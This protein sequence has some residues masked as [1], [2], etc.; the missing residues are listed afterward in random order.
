LEEANYY[1]EA[2]GVTK[3]SIKTWKNQDHHKNY[4]APGWQKIIFVTKRVAEKLSSSFLITSKTKNQKP[5]TNPRMMP[6]IEL[7]PQ[8]KT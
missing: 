1:K 3:A 6:S 2:N 7:F 8:P 5:K 4:Q